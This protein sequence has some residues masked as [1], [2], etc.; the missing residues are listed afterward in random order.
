MSHLV[1]TYPE[2]VKKQE[3]ISNIHFGNISNHFLKEILAL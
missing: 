1:E 3:N 2:I